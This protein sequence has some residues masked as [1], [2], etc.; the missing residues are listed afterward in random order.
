MTTLLP[1]LMKATIAPPPPSLPWRHCQQ[2]L[3]ASTQAARTTLVLLT[4]A[5]FL[6]R[7][8]G[9]RG[10]PTA[11]RGLLRQKHGLDVRKDSTLRD[12]DPGEKL[13]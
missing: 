9:S 11:G 2:L 6:S 10:S 13:V 1:E 8:S 3:S 7:L 12:G 5:G 4:L